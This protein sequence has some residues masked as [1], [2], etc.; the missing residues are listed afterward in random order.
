MTIS[1]GGNVF[2]IA[3]ERG[4]DWR[5]I[6]DFS[7]SINPL[8]PSPLVR[9]AIRDAIDRIVH[10]P[11][12]RSE[13]LARALSDLWNVDPAAILPGNG[14]TELI[15]F[16][17]QVEPRN[18]VTLVVPTF[19]EF[20][21]VYPRAPRAQWNEAWPRDGF[22]VLTNPNNPI[23]E[24]RELDPDRAML[25]D[26]SFIDFTGHESLVSRLGGELI[27]L[28]SLTKFYAMPGL[29][30]G[31]VVAHPDRIRRWE[32]L[33]PPWQVN[34][35]AEAAA[36]AA[37]ADQ[38]HARRTREFVAAERAWLGR[39]LSQLPGLKPHASCANYLLVDCPS[40]VARRLV[41]HKILVREIGDRQIRIAVRTR[42][43]NERLLR[44]LEEVLCG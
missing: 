3:R 25:V 16:I 7:A 11:E 21:R 23:G 41:P 37:V 33:R 14:A 1:H 24:F 18:D 32:A 22:L 29:R 17:A 19:S 8:G 26:E 31:V 44:A 15:H 9:E 27:V 35:L 43:E 40:D 34:V 2:A 6:A 30:I 28:R 20:L 42:E 38:E 39:S 12:Q 5:E 10:Y 4:W 36:L 13:R